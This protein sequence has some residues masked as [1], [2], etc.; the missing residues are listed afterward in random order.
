MKNPTQHVQTKHIDVQH[1]FVGKRVENGGH[2]GGC[3]YEG[4]TKRMT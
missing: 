3:A 4:I 1:H 2:G